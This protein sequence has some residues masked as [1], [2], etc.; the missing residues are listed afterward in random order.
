MVTG[1]TTPAGRSGGICAAAAGSS[2]DPRRG[3]WLPG[4]PGL[5]G[6]L[7]GDDFSDP[8]GAGG[9]DRVLVAQ[10]DADLAKRMLNC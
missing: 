7:G 8:L 10:G 5:A 1:R 3:A 2:R 4:R 6:D 9:Q